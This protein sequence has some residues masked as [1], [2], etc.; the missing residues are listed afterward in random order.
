MHRSLQ[1]DLFPLLAARKLVLVNMYW[2][3]LWERKRK[4]IFLLYVNNLSLLYCFKREEG[5]G[6]VFFG[7]KAEVHICY[8][9]IWILKYKVLCKPVSLFFF[10]FSFWGVISIVLDLHVKIFQLDATIGLS[11]L[12]DGLSMHFFICCVTSH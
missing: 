8:L 9:T 4:S 1:P 5:D 10:L 11:F 6:F 7:G 3:D 12:E 2:F